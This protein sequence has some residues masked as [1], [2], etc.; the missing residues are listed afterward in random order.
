MGLY[1]IKRS[2]FT[3]NNFIRHFFTK[4]GTLLTNLPSRGKYVGGWLTNGLANEEEPIVV[5][6]DGT[7]RRF[8]DL[9]GDFPPLSLLGNSLPRLSRKRFPLSNLIFSQQGAEEPGVGSCR[10]WSS[11]FMAL[12]TNNQL[13]VVSYY[14]EPPS[15][16]LLL[17]KERFLHS[18]QYRLLINFC[19]LWKL[20]NILVSRPLDDFLFSLLK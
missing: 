6:E 8:L 16:L 3:L 15:Y 11:G 9:Y 7:L 17:L 20:S 10:F 2:P 12:L 18:L 4:A 14:K 5:T 1:I 19:V 13:I